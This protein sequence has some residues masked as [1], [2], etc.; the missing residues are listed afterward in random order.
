[1]FAILKREL[2]SYWTTVTGPLFV[3]INLFFLGVYFTAYHL[4]MGYPHVSYTVQSVLFVFLIVTP[5]LTMRSMALEKSNRTDQLLFTAPVSPAGVI[6]GKYLGMIGI[7]MI[8]VIM[9]CLY[10]PVLSAFGHV[11]MAESYV[12]ILAY[13][14]FGATCLAIGL[15]VSSLTENLII[16]SVGTFGI[17]FLCYLM[18]GIRRLISQ[19]GNLLTKILRVFDISS[20]LNDMMQ[21]VLDVNA[22]LY[23]LS[24]IFLM[25]FFTHQVINSRRYEFSKKTAKLSVFTWLGTVIVIAIVAGL[26]FAATLI[27]ETYKNIDV[28]ENKLYELTDESKEYLKGL[29]KDVKLCVLSKEEDYD[30]TLKQLLYRYES[31]SSHIKVEYVDIG[32]NPDFAKQYGVESAAEGSVIV[33]SDQRSK[34]IRYDDLY[35]TQIDYNTYQQSV[36]GFDGEGQITGAIDYVMD[37]DIPVVYTVTGH[38]EQQPGSSLTAL[39]DKGNIEVREL[40]LMS[41]GEVPEDAK[42]IFLLSPGTDYSEDDVKAVRA[43]LDKGGRALITSTYTQGGLK[44]FDS[45]IEAYGVSL[46]EGVVVEGSDKNYYQMPT[47]L[48]PEIGASTITSDLISEKRLVLMTYARGAMVGKAQDDTISVTPLLTTSDRSWAKH[49]TQNAQSYDKEEGDADGPF[50]LGLFVEKELD[51]GT[52]K[53]LYFTSDSILDDM[54]DSMVAGANSSLVMKGL[55]E[56]IEEKESSIA[57]PAKSY[58]EDDIIVP[59]STAILTGALVTGA[60][61]LL[62]FIAGMIIWSRRRRL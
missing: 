49:D 58:E 14:L 32:V 23:Y 28:T 44:N 62:I 12:S 56:M 3:A 26:N 17:L 13:F 8:P 18:A 1:M 11:P 2:K 34:Y 55:G 29:D 21:G 7:F 47:Y 59:R 6:W 60:V 25:L 4:N 15:F 10:P 35:E 36:T 37:E 39:L 53:I 30:S 51:S 27:P 5:V 33:V 42:A 50:T 52:A 46:A 43:Y 20:P 24:V 57:I 22:V 61:P 9:L 31:A 41:A 40:N 16:A 19:E 38:G 45:I 48:L 54:V